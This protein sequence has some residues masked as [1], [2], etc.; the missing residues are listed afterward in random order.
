M[1]TCPNQIPQFELFP[2][3]G[4]VGAYRPA[5]RQLGVLACFLREGWILSWNEYS[6]YVLD[7]VNEVLQLQQSQRDIHVDCMP[8]EAEWINTGILLVNVEIIDD[9]GDTVTHQHTTIIDIYTK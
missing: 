8:T 3:P 1:S 9:D 2:R 5:D 4:P 6:I 7:S